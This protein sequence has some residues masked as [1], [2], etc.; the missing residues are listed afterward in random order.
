MAETP[1]QLLRRAAALL[2]AKAKPT[3][4]STPLPGMAFPVEN[5]EELA[6][7]EAEAATLGRVRESIRGT[8]GEASAG[9]AAAPGAPTGGPVVPRPA[10]ARHLE[11]FGEAL[12][13]PLLETT[14]RVEGLNLDRATVDEANR[15]VMAAIVEVARGRITRAKG[16]VRS[17]DQTT[18]DAIK[19]I[20][21]GTITPELLIGL[22]PRTAPAG[23]PI[24]D[25]QTA[26]VSL[27]MTR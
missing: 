21:Q 6:K 14:G 8:R 9:G 13:N 26:P 22:P 11:R 1:F 4:P 24:A 20:E 7:R 16:G 23:I 5:V 18:K 2:R 3:G 12:A 25:F 17:L 19:L 27:G 10:S 15:R